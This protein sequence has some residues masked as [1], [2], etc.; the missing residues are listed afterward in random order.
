[1]S[2]FFISSL[3]TA[4]DTNKPSVEL[5]DSRWARKDIKRS[6]R[7]RHALML[8]GGTPHLCWQ[9][10]FLFFFLSSVSRAGRS[11]IWLPRGFHI[12]RFRCRRL[13][14][15]PFTFLWTA[16]QIPQNRENKPCLYIL[17]CIDVI[18]LRSSPVDTPSL[19]F[20]LSQRVHSTLLF[21]YRPATWMLAVLLRLVF[22][23]HCCA[24]CVMR[25]GQF[26]LSLRPK[27]FW[28]CLPVESFLSFIFGFVSASWWFRSVRVSSFSATIISGYFLSA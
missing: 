25:P 18:A 9:L 24:F 14:S 2:F 4:R 13:L 12:Y 20:C 3:L 26:E 11:N 10:R 1:M 16:R 5:E 27:V 28:F 8:R 21:Y 15:F 6:P 19:H 7:M 23:M 22:W 17:A